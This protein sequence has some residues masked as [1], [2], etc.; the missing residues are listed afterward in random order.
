MRCRI[1]RVVASFVLLLLFADI[2]FHLVDPYYHT[3]D[4]VAADFQIFSPDINA[5]CGVA[6]HEGTASH[7]NHYPTLPSQVA[8]PLPFLALAGIVNLSTPE[9]TH[10]SAI[11]PIGRAP[12]VWT[13]A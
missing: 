6:G 4:C 9:F 7:H 5:G 12:P 1:Q 11:R 3:A 10:T 13:R 2:G 8:A